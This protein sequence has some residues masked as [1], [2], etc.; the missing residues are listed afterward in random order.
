MKRLFLLCI[1][2]LSRILHADSTQ[3]SVY[4]RTYLA[5]N[6][7]SFRPS[8]PEMVSMARERLHI[9]YDGKQILQ[10]IALASISLNEDKIAR[11]FLPNTHMN[12]TSFIAGE[13]GSQAVLNEQDDVIANY[14]NVLTSTPFA[15]GSPVN[16][17][18][19]TFESSVSFSP[20]Q[21]TFGFALDYYRHLSKTQDSGWWFELTFPLKWVRNDLGLKETVIEPGGPG[22]DNPDVPAGYVPNMTAAFK[23][24]KFQFG[25]IDGA[26]SA[27][28][29]AD[30]FL[31]L[32]YTYFNYDS[33]HFSTYWGAVIPT[34]NK[35]KGEYVFEPIFGNGGHAGVFSGAAIGVR[36]WHDCTKA[37]YWELETCGTLLMS[38]FQTRSFDLKDKTWGRYIWVYTSNKATSTAPGINYFTQLLEVTPGTSRD[39]NLGFTLESRCYRIEAGYHYYARESEKAKLKT[40]WN[41]NIALASIVTN[42]GDFVATDQTKFSRSRET[43]S[44]YMGVLNDST[45]G[46]EYFKIVTENDLD[47]NSAT[48]PGTVVH[49]FYGAASFHWGCDCH[50]KFIGLGATYNN[51][52]D[53]TT[54]DRIEVWGKFGIEF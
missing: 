38:N 29:I 31:K 19:Y 28:G 3:D 10:L 16:F 11:Y 42:A 43:I 46:V 52:T 14:F 45:G 36:A 48:H 20:K 24:N 2:F 12:R 22:G 15:G 18:N 1:I 30:I 40:P 4:K 27:F 44:D 35:P 25:K 8:S 41:L 26:Q 32:G 5:S 23:Q 33:R 13:L 37:L 7:S 21:Y 51:A 6:P 49:T 53:N 47:I 54:L 50:P 9:C 34:S 17:S 39:L